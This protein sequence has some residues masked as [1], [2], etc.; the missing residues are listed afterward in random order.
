LHPDLQSI[1]G[2]QGARLLDEFR[3]RR[4]DTFLDEVDRQDFLTTLAVARLKSDFIKRSPSSSGPA[5]VAHA[6]KNK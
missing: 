2:L 4:E 5:S 3:N 1:P 6:S